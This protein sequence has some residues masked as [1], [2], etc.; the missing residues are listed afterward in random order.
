MDLYTV[1]TETHPDTM[2]DV[3]GQCGNFLCSDALTLLKC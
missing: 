2:T 1:N 3:T